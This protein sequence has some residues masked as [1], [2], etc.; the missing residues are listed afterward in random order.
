MTN[1]QK[2]LSATGLFCA[3]GISCSRARAPEKP[4][5]I[6]SQALA[7]SADG[8][9][10]DDGGQVDCSRKIGCYDCG[11]AG[12]VWR[13]PGSGTFDVGT[14]GACSPTL[15]AGVVDVACYRPLE[16]AQCTPT[17]SCLLQGGGFVPG[18]W[19]FCP[20]DFIPIVPA[21]GQAL[22]IEGTQL[23]MACCVTDDCGNNETCV[24]RKCCVRGTGSCQQDDW[25]CSGR[26]IIPPGQQ[27]GTC[28]CIGSG[29]QGCAVGSDCCSNVCNSGTCH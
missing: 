25:C 12:I 22:V 9:G 23:S 21:A 5:G 20:G 13:P 24:N 19:T 14:N 27:R 10:G 15:R 6:A 2:V 11:A 17:L 18:T 3:L 8:A 7:F 4:P 26:C 1:V 16:G 29:G 28:Q